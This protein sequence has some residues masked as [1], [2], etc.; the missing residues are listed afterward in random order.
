MTALTYDVCVVGAGI[1][2]LYAARKCIRENLRVVVLEK[3]GAHVGGRIATKYY[4]NGDQYEAGAGRF[5]ELHVKL[6]RLIREAGLTPVPINTDKVYRGTEEGRLMNPHM[7]D[8]P[9]LRKPKDLRGMSFLEW[10]TDTYGETRAKAFQAAFGY[11]GEFGCMNAYDALGVFE[12]DF[13]PEITY[14]GL[15][16]GLSAVVNHLVAGLPE[17]TLRMGFG[18]DKV[19]YD[20]KTRRFSVNDGAVFAKVL[21]L[22]VPKK[23]LGS[24]F[25]ERRAWL[26]S[27]VCEVPLHR[28]YAK[29]PRGGG[30]LDGLVRTTTDGPLRQVIPVGNGRIVMVSYSDTRF[31]DYWHRVWVEKGQRGFTR[32]IMR[33]LRALVG[34]AVKVPS[35]LY[36]R[37]YYWEV[38]V[39]LW[40]MGVDSRTARK[41]ATHRLMGDGC[42]CFVVGEAFAKNQA[43]IEGALESVDY[44]WPS[45]KSFLH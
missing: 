37:S 17:G 32:E 21:V 2:G 44:V 33:E 12:R 4:P 14:Y 22:A 41:E 19:E 34:P 24:L 40:T 45:V 9:R 15:K 8:N 6:L 28:V 18:V 1:A 7:R 10:L 5:N 29:F 26:D 43:W 27:L 25:P 30:R 36:V 3:S 38:G 35:P 42:P 39:H 23:A 31:A 11:D 13:K 16:E 20:A